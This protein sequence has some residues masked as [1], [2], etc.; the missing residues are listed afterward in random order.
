MTTDA[1]KPVS[2]ESDVK[3]LFRERDRQSM[4]SHFDLWSHDD[5]SRHADAILGRLRDGTMPCDGS[6]TQAQVDLFQRWADSGKPR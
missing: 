5:V 6:W 4:Q 1:G 2:F 3:P